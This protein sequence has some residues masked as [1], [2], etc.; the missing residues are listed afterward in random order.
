MAN[1][2]KSERAETLDCATMS[3]ELWASHRFNEHCYFYPMRDCP[4]W[5]EGGM[6]GRIR[7]P[8]PDDVTEEGED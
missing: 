4:G 6:C 8:I 7:E 3:E 2:T 1:L 5:H